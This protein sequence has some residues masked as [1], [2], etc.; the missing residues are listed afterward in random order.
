M[1]TSQ[2]HLSYGLL[3]TL[4][5]IEWDF[6]KNLSFIKIKNEKKITFYHINY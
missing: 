6:L 2:T 4:T 1:I 5:K 3:M